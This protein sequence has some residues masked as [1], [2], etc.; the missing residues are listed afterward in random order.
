MLH[1]ITLVCINYYRGCIIFKYFDKYSLFMFEL[2][3]KTQK[4]NNNNIL[5]ASKH[6]I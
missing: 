5:T 4:K 6:S 1:S 2:I 3:L